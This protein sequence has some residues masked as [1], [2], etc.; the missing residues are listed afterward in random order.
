MSAISAPT[1]AST[2]AQRLAGGSVREYLCL[3]ASRRVGYLNLRQSSFKHRPVN[4][5]TVVS[6][7]RHEQDDCMLHLYLSAWPAP[8]RRCT[9]FLGLQTN[10]RGS[11]AGRVARHAF[12]AVAAAV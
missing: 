9:L 7:T 10:C 4:F 11:T 3:Q 12:Q 5:V 2:S 6:C 8:P 1:R